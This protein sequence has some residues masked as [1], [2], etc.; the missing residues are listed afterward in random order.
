MKILQLLGIGTV[1]GMAVWANIA[2]AGMANYQ[3]IEG[4]ETIKNGQIVSFKDEKH[5]LSNESYDDNIV[6]I[7]VLR[8]DVALNLVGQEGSYPV[9]SDG[10]AAVLVSAAEGEIKPGDFITTS[11][12]PGVAVKALHPGFVVGQAL[13]E[14][15]DSSEGATGLVKTKLSLRWADVDRT[16]L[17]DR[18]LTKRLI[19]RIGY[20][21][22]LSTLAALEE[23][24]TALRFTLATII[25]FLSFMFGFYVFGRVASNGVSALGRNPLARRSITFGIAVNVFITVA[26]TMAGVIVAVVIL[27]Y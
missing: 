11:K 5:V 4:E 16:L 27:T 20:G 18:P 17:P 7:V 3:I 8:P 25:L 22:Q 2:Y 13:E 6:G 14:F 10:E 1:I 21:F 26:I 12:Q 9:I 24:S 15:T 19:D 23:P